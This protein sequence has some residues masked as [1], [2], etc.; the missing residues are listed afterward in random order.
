MIIA[1]MGH[2]KNPNAQAL[3]RLGGEARAEKLS[4]EKIAKIAS[5]GGKARAAKLTA[6]ERRRIAR[7]AVAARER[8][9]KEK[10]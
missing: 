5:K 6:A 9:R 2:K 8:K 10:S 4:D 1:S 7:L 3:G